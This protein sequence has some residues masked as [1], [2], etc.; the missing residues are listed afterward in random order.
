MTRKIIPGT[1]PYAPLIG[2]S[3]GAAGSAAAVVF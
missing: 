2:F 1:S 3:R